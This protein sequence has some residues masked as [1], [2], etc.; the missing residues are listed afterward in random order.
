[1][2]RELAFWLG[3]LLVVLWAFR[4]FDRG[5]SPGEIK[6]ATQYDRYLLGILVYAALSFVAYVISAMLFL[7]AYG[8][9]Y[10]LFHLT[11]EYGPLRT[12]PLA[13]GGTLIVI[14]ILPEAPYLREWIDSFRAF[15]RTI[16]LYP[17]AYRRMSSL[18]STSKF[19][20]ARDSNQA[21]QQKLGRYGSVFSALSHQLPP[22]VRQDLLEIQSL[23]DGFRE[24]TETSRPGAD[25]YPRKLRWFIATRGGDFEIA[26]RNYQRLIRRAAQICALDRVVVADEDVPYP[27][28]DFFVHAAER[29]LLRYR[30]LISQA[31]LSC[32][33]GGKA[34]KEFIQKFGY[35]APPDRLLPYWPLLLILVLDACLF[36]TPAIF[37]AVPAVPSPSI[38]TLFLFGHGL[39][40]VFAVSL[41]IFPK[42][43]SNFARPSLRSF[44]W[45][46]YAVFGSTSYALGAFILLILNYIAFRL[47]ATPDEM[48]PLNN[49]NPYLLGLIFSLYFPVITIFVS[50]LTDLH[51]R[52]NGGCNWG[53]RA[54]DALVT[55]SVMG[56]THLLVRVII[57]LISGAPPQGWM[58]LYITVSIGALVGFLIPCTAAVYLNDSESR[59]LYDPGQTNSEGTPTI[60]LGA[61]LQS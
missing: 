51:L 28:S 18:L 4:D 40:Q 3:A 5:L 36:L 30:R 23:R 33:A 2:L 50:L 43:T 9:M 44:P 58:F 53:G 60:G 10:D 42:A 46:S 52:R 54:L 15:S 14:A 45:R 1:V 48:P 12:L 55:A 37:G 47:V 31:A 32:F 34:R 22:S 20:P 13:M 35:A 6:S 7:A 16:A 57:Y 41:A 8:L 19:H 11:P 24:L 61:T 56:G 17:I 59:D 21:L 25:K 38:L 26:E 49:I 39:A 27:L 29:L